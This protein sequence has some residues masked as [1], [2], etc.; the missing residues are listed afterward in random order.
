MR[1]VGRVSIFDS[2]D[3]IEGDGAAILAAED[4]MYGHLE[5]NGITL[6]RYAPPVRRNVPREKPIDASITFVIP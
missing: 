6:R 2:M 1:V 5:T 3:G 4:H